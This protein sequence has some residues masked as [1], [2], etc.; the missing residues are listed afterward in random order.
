MIGIVHRMSAVLCAPAT[1]SFSNWCWNFMSN[2]PFRI[3]ASELKARARAHIIKIKSMFTFGFGTMEWKNNKHN[4]LTRK[5]KGFSETRE[6]D[7]YVRNACVHS[8]WEASPPQYN[9]IAFNAIFMHV[10]R[11]TQRTLSAAHY[12]DVYQYKSD[13]KSYF[14]RE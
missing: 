3:L 11:Q 9:C 13:T 5:W 2:T 1:N 12:H 6:R 7:K 4:A 10:K 14:I 8:K